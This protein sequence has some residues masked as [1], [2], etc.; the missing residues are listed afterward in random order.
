MPAP[1]GVG[2]LGWLSRLSVS[3]FIASSVH[4]FGFTVRACR[5]AFSLLCVS[6]CL[7]SGLISQP[8]VSFSSFLLKELT[9]LFVL[10]SQLACLGQLLAPVGLWFAPVG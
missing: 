5:P 1:A 7:L 6:C 9:C 4:L 3:C 2:V 10:L 8:A